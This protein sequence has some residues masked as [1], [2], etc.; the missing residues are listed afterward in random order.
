MPLSDLRRNVENAMDQWSRGEALKAQE[1][2]AQGD[3]PADDKAAAIDADRPAQAPTLPL[4]A[5][6][7]ARDVAWTDVSSGAGIGQKHI[8]TIAW[9]IADLQDR[10]MAQLKRGSL[11]AT[12]SV[13]TAQ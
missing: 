7:Q 8:G 4:A 10:H 5:P 13:Q 3:A 12:S 2:A 6:V 11:A 9:S 1:P